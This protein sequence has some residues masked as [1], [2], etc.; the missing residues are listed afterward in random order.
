[1]N[2][3]ILEYMICPACLPEEFPLTLRQAAASG[4]EVFEGALRCTHCGEAF[5]IRE[6]TA[7]LVPAGEHRRRAV[8]RRYETPD[9]L[10]AY[11]WSHYSDLFKDTEAATA[12]AEWGEQ[13]SAGGG[14]G[15][16]AGCATGRFTFEMAKKCDFVIGIDMSEGFV[17]TARRILRD[18]KLAFQVREEGMIHTERSFAL[19]ES[20]EPRNVEF[21]VGD[22]QAL[23]FRSGIFSRVASLNLLDK[24]PRPLDHLREANRVAC[25]EESELLI[26]DPFSWSEDVCPSGDWLGGTL[27]GPLRGPALDNISRILSDDREFSPSWAISRRGAVW[28]K[29]RNHANHFELIRSLYIM[30]RRQPAGNPAKSPVRG[31]AEL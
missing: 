26:S 1:M 13:I 18:R 3:K 14:V 31:A 23:P 9:L 28:W 21:I 29:I 19:P 17:S 7:R 11:L 27:D 30:A 25:R 10:S 22:A 24:V 8:S 15:L 5:P 4:D 12:Y 2:R 6:G 16:D 20:W